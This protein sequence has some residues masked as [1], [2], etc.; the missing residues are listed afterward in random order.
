MKIIERR[1]FNAAWRAY[2]T[3]HKHLREFDFGY[4]GFHLY[5]GIQKRVGELWGLNYT[6]R[7]GI[8]PHIATDLSPLQI[9][10]LHA[11]INCSPDN[12]WVMVKVAIAKHKVD[13]GR[14]ETENA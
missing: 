6:D 10:K 1:L 3:K 13:D 11:I 8:H 4:S 2:R 9:S 12:A 5:L 7:D 14:K